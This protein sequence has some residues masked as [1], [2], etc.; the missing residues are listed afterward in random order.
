MR[1]MTAC[2]L[3]IFCILTLG[4][5]LAQ[6]LPRTVLWAWETPQSLKFLV[7]F[8]S[9]IGVAF[10]ARTVV[11][12]GNDVS[13]RPRMQPLRV[14]PETYLVAV[15]RIEPKTPAMTLEQVNQ[16]AE[17]IVEASEQRGVRELQIDFDARRS[18]REFYSRVLREV[19][20]RG[21]KKRITITALASWCMGDR[22]MS[23]L[24]IDGAV[25]MLFRLG[26]ERNLVRR[27]WATADK[28]PLCRENVGVSTD[29]ASLELG[30]RRI[31]WFHPGPWT[32]ADVK[33]ALLEGKRQ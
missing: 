15:V 23:G 1:L 3:L 25:P 14:S 29:E 28:D 30:A 26:A 19:K 9:E 22:W 12:A 4:C 21:P 16:V 33:K 32:E 17:A 10:L 31:F 5:G 27:T 18:E 7:K 6:E 24:E 20:K 8:R 11:V 13:V 2:K